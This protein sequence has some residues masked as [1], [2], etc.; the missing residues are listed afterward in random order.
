MRYFGDYKSQQKGLGG[1]KMPP[2]HTHTSWVL[3][4]HDFRPL[5]LIRDLSKA[6]KIL[7]LSNNLQNADY[8]LILIRVI[9]LDYKLISKKV[10]KLIQLRPL[11]Y[12]VNHNYHAR[13]H[14]QFTSV[15]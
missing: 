5:G 15:K 4:F 7:G 6:R 8:S 2:T 1:W 3:R 10:T 9:N 14:I 13:M 11:G 12:L